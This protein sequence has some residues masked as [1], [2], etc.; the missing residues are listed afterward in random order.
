MKT[1]TTLI[2]AFFMALSLTSA[3]D[4]I[5]FYK[6]GNVI[7]KHAIAQIDSIIFYIAPGSNPQKT[8]IK[9]GDGNVYDTISIG[10]QTWFVENLRTTKYK[11]GS[12]I[13]WVPATND[14]SVLTTPGYCA[15]NN[16]TNTD[17]IKTYG[18][19][20]NWF[21]ITTNNL[22]PTDWHVPAETEFNILVTYLGGANAAG[23]LLKETGTSHWN[24]TQAE[25]TNSSQFTATPGGYR[26]G[27]GGSNPFGYMRSGAYL[28]SS[29]DYNL[30]NGVYRHLAAQSAIVDGTL[31]DKHAGMSVRCAKDKVPTITT[32]SITSITTTTANSG[33]NVISVNGKPITETG[34]CWST[35]QHPTTSNNKFTTGSPN[36]GEF[37]L[38]L[39]GLNTGT[40]Y[41]VRAYAINGAGTGYGNEVSFTTK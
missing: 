19:L 18:L 15:Y 28:W 41:Y 31:S 40:T 8:T 21:A 2:I 25:V 23:A 36:I 38:L 5:Y 9:D 22:C 32:N 27:G 33:G 26:N 17:T 20:Y 34:I 12:S 11:D 6:S 35:T 30:G 7:N 16:T 37:L 3:Q 14:W 1:L 10:T 4:T 39:T 29:T 24:S 13:P